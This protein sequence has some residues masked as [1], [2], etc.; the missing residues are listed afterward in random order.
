V[1][2]CALSLSHS[3]FLTLII[4]FSLTHFN[5]HIQHSHSLFLVH[6][7]YYLTHS[8]ILSLS[9]LHFLF[10]LMLNLVE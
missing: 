5:Y 10:L 8:L 7:H 2:E 9:F 6:F 3:L 4:T 1:L